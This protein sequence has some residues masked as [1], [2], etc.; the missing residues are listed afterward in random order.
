MPIPDY[1]TT[2][3]PLL[4]YAGDGTEHTLREAVDYLAEQFK[5]TAQE[6]NAL[7]PSGQQAVFINRVGWAR[8]Y[9]KKAGLLESPRRGYFKITNR[10]LKVLKDA[11][12]R[13]DVSYLKQF[14]EFVEFQTPRK[15]KETSREFEEIEA[16]PEESIGMGYKKIREDLEAELLDRVKKCSPDFFEKLVVE[17]I[18]KMGYGG[19]RQDAGQAI[20]KTGDEGIDGVIKEDKLGLDNVY[21]QA[22]KWENTV[23]RAEIQKFAGALQ[24]QR[25]RKGI[26]IT[27]SSFQKGALEYVSKI[28]SKIV[29]IDGHELTELMVDNNVGVSPMAVYEI[30]K[31][32]EDFFEL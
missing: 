24:G 8:T 7:L 25:A 2:M 5:L 12:P 11:P 22:K 17:L 19:S 16:T 31:M 23:S 13:I 27:T 32:D 1:Q 3:L 18:V 28:D 26:F 4:T 30:K 6:R 29:L 15:K 21:I 14:P 9:L 10:G 20:G